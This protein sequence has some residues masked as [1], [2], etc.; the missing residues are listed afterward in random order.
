MIID[1]DQ[2]SQLTAYTHVRRG[3]DVVKIRCQGQ[4]QVWFTAQNIILYN[5]ILVCK[6]FWNVLF[7]SQ[8]AFCILFITDQS[9]RYEH[10][11]RC[12]QD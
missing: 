12:V 8:L 5:I 11:V 7:E 10:R 9:K 6:Y 3:S 2:T 4:T 1:Q